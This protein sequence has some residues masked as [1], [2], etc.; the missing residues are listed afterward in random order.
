MRKNLQEA[1]KKKGLTQEQA[2]NALGIPYNSYR[3]YE[4]GR[5]GTKV[6]T[7]DTIEDFFGVPQ[8]ELRKLFP[9]ER[10]RCLTCGQTIR[11]KDRVDKV[12][13]TASTP[14]DC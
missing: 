14:S 1:R 9:V 12:L 8:R 7:W 3:A 13:Q 4:Y 2:A 10:P 6:E 5:S 11:K